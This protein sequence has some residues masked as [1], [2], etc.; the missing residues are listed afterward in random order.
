MHF[1]ITR[2]YWLRLLEYDQIIQPAGRTAPKIASSSNVMRFTSLLQDASLFLLAFF[3][4]NHL[5][6][7]TVDLFQSNPQRICSFDWSRVG[8]VVPKAMPLVRCFCRSVISALSSTL[9]SDLLFQR[10]VRWDC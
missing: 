8:A 6:W 2:L 10:F 5:N 7:L 1:T 3:S 9:A 4:D